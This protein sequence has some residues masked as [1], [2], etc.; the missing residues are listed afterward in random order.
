MKKTQISLLGLALFAS[1]FLLSACGGKKDDALT[2]HFRYWG[3]GPEVTIISGLM[4]DFEKQ[5]PGV[6][7]KD[8]RKIMNAQTYADSL[9]TEFA[10]GAGPDVIFM[11]AEI[12]DLLSEKDLLEDLSPLVA[13]DAELDLKSYY[14]SVVERF[15]TDGRLL[16][17]PRDIAPF[18]CV[19]YNKKL[20][21]AKKVPYPTDDW[22]WD[23]LTSRAKALTERDSHGVA[24]V[25]GFAD[26]WLM[27]GAWI[28][29]S[30]GQL[31]D[32]YAAPKRV[33]LDSEK[34]MRGVLQ[35]WDL[36]YTHKVMPLAADNKALTGGT[37]GQFVNGTLAMFYSGIWKTP[38]FR[39]IK[40]FDWDIAMFPKGPE[41]VRGF[42]SGGSG[43]G[44]R[45]GV[46][47]KELAWKLVKYLA[48]PEGQKRLTGT[49]LTQ[50]AIK[51]LAES[52]VFLD[53]QKPANKKMLLKAAM[54]A[55]HP[56]ASSKWLNFNTGVWNPI[57]DPI[58]VPGFDRAGVP[59]LIKK[60]VSE[61]NAKLFEKK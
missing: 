47:N 34:A 17:L 14:P 30:G 4:R 1:A 61:G 41:G 55:T 51:S 43:Y 27:T 29:S 18:A 13:A 46:A 33:T 24:K 3:D 52:P 54:I 15:S 21:D 16:A 57:M 5:N 59:A 50:P 9:T 8:E 19:Y 53:G 36:M 44:I 31:V 40:A 35:R 56:P 2:L 6:R 7:I 37:A 45:K 12:K 10:A 60:A 26:D 48:G 25:L 39:S 49:G 11:A 22:D 28:L 20:F 38:E 42:D 58:W 23:G 32:N